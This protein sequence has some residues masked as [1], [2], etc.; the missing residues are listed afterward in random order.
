[1]WEIVGGKIQNE[2]YISHLY[3]KSSSISG[4][5]WNSFIFTVSDSIIWRLNN[6]SLTCSG[7][8]VSRN[9]V[10]RSE[11]T[12]TVFK[13]LRRAPS[14]GARP[15]PTRDE[16]EV[17]TCILTLAKFCKWNVQSWI[18]KCKGLLSLSTN[19][20]SSIKKKT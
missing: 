14:L 6:K 12:K 16:R 19:S 17:V 15:L 8:L 11:Y 13:A 7:K 20:N 9:S 18:M 10:S 5:S 2:F 3:I 4:S 1:M